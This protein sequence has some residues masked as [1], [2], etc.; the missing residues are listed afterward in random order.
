MFAVY[1]DDIE[2]FVSETTPLSEDI[3]LRNYLISLS[4]HSSDLHR[5]RVLLFIFIFR[6]CSLDFTFLYFWTFVPETF[7]TKSSINMKISIFAGV[8]LISAAVLSVDGQSWAEFQNKH[9]KEWMTAGQCTQVMRAKRIVNPPTQVNPRISCKTFN[10]F[11]IT[12]D[13]N[14]VRAICGRG[15]APYGNSMRISTATFPIVDCN[16]VNQ[17]PPAVPYNCRYNGV[18]RY[19]RRIIVRCENGEPVHFHR[20]Q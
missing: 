3:R 11:I 2:L 5:V 8:L 1:G 19:N 18:P 6:L 4:E 16:L 7:S 10:T 14:A 15:G 17:N 9:I 20:S 13:V 12:E